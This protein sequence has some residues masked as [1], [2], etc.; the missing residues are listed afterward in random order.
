MDRED[1]FVQLLPITNAHKAHLD[2]VNVRL[3]GVDITGD[4]TH[5]LLPESEAQSSPES[6]AE[7]EQHLKGEVLRNWPYIFVGAFVIFLVT[8]GLIIWKCCC[9][10]GQKAS[11]SGKNSVLPFSSKP[12]NYNTLREVPSTHM[13]STGGSRY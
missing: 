8:I 11:N 13:Q 12:E 10:R 7:K 6:K 5:Q 2:F 4:A 3:N 9:H 1:P